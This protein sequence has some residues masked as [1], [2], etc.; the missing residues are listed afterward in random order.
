M[1]PGG[2]ER[3]VK[4]N[5]AGKSTRVH[6]SRS[7]ETC[8][9]RSK[10]WTFWA[11]IISMSRCYVL[12]NFAQAVCTCVV[13]YGS[14]LRCA[15]LDVRSCGIIRGW[16][17]HPCANMDSPWGEN[18]ASSSTFQ[19]N[20]SSLGAIKLKDAVKAKLSEF[21]G[22]Y[23]DDVLAVSCVLFYCPYVFLHCGPLAYWRQTTLPLQASCSAWVVEEVII[24]WKSWISKICTNIEL[25]RS[26]GFRETV[27]STVGKIHRVVLQSCW[28]S[29]GRG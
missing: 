19:L 6:R 16:S 2:E 13:G 25:C 23:T 10:H 8:R 26:N 29:R 17:L 27:K 20:V 18:T 9:S 5:F 12:K 24:S 15:S 11:I 22:S 3:R 14:I 28:Q 1:W 4:E 21:M 7:N